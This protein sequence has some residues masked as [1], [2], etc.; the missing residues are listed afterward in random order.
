MNYGCEED[1]PACFHFI[2]VHVYVFM[3]FWGEGA[4]NTYKQTNKQQKND[5]TQRII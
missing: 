2:R 5:H 4:L 3:F 1:F